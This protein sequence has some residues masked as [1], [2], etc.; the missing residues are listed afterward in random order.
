MM[1]GKIKAFTLTELVVVMLISAVVAALSYGGYRIITSQLARYTASGRGL[2]D[3][4]RLHYLLEKDFA[5]AGQINRRQNGITC[6]T[7][8]GNSVSY[9]FLADRIVR[10]Q[11]SLTDTFKTNLWNLELLFEGKAAG[12]GGLADEIAFQAT[13]EGEPLYFH[14]TKTYAPDVLMRFDARGDYQ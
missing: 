3:H 13:D 2:L 6:T 12:D 9:R 5:Q 10:K 11:Q 1:R 8:E 7:S 4:A 14:F